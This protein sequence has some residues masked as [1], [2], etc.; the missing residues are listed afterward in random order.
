M[1]TAS[2][3]KRK[4]KSG[5]PGR[6]TC[7]RQPEIRALRRSCRKVRSVVAFPFERMLA[8]LRERCSGESQSATVSPI[9]FR[10]A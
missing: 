3:C 6:F 1:K 5:L 4:M 2:R 8:M 7:L 9:P 10:V